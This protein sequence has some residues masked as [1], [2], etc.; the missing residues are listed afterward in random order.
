[1][2]TSEASQITVAEEKPIV[3]VVACGSVD[4]GK[5]TL[6]GRLLAETTSV[7]DDLLDQV[8]R[9]RRGGST[10][11]I[12]EPDF[13]LLTDGLE[14]EQS[15]GITIDVAYRH[16]YLP[17]GR[18]AIVADAPGHEQYTRNMAVAASTADI[19]ILLV[20]ATR[21]IRPQTHRHLLI[22]ALMGVRTVIVAVNKMDAVGY[23]QSI[24][25]QVVNDVR[26]LIGRVQITDTTVIPISAL[27]GD[28]VTNGSQAMVWYTGP[29]LLNALSRWDP[30]ALTDEPMGARLPIQYV[31]RAD[32]F[33]GYAGTVASGRLKVGDD[34]SVAQSG[35]VAKV[36]RMLVAGQDTTE[37]TPGAAVVV[38]LDPAV[39]AARGDVLVN[40][41]TVRAAELLAR[42]FFADVVW[43]GEQ[44]L[45]RGRSY[46]LMAGPCSVPVVITAVRGRR[47]M[48]TGLQL[49]AR[50]LAINDIGVVD[51]VTDK[52][53]L[54]DEY[55]RCRDIG[56]FILVDRLTQDTVA[57]GMIRHVLRRG[58]NVVPQVF[59][60]DRMDRARLK[61]QRPCVMWLTGLP[62]S[63]KSTIADSLERHLNL[64][65]LHTYVLDGDNIR[66]GLNKDL[67]FT[68]EDRAENVRRVAEVAK[69]M[70]D[71]GLI[72]IVA[73]VSPFASD[74]RAARD[75]FEPG[76]FIEVFIDTP[77]NVC[78]QRDPKG[79]YAKAQAGLLHNMTGVGQ[80]YEPPEVP[81]V[82]VDGTADL[83]TSVARLAEVIL[84]TAHLED[85]R[86]PGA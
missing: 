34:V 71:A 56:G 58:H 64:V 53:I 43:T 31:I 20:D 50:K 7:P 73:L 80:R 62:G 46:L 16:L 68:A 9:T 11:P 48:A 32:G 49:A 17:S 37:A 81:E 41:L 26:P 47:D 86:P 44:P 35:V 83:N 66:T 45:M 24:F 72:V 21:G 25:D 85:K 15:Q 59:T 82:I 5:S 18:R 61:D 60:I 54:L 67:G 78:I 12:G 10:I 33:R 84:S 13:S 38:V 52:P 3:R 28:N 57:A 2:T 6:I 63:G 51:I 65:G 30:P 55:R 22:C 77:A 70:L 29:T 1:M 69:L 4:D 42:A 14:G 39:D 8:R 79:L 76:H 40:E 75:L 19:A 36:T 74:R 23:S 27:A